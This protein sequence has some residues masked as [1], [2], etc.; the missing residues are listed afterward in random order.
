MYIGLFDVVGCVIM[1]K[2][3]IGD[4]EMGLKLSDYVVLVSKLEGFF[5]SDIVN[6]V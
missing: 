1:F 3:V 4:I 5:G 6:V 2:L